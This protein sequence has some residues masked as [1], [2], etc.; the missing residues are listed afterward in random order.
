VIIK[1]SAGIFLVGLMTLQ[2][3][4]PEFV[5]AVSLSLDLQMLESAE[6]GSDRGVE[7]ASSQESLVFGMSKAACAHVGDH[8][9][10]L[11]G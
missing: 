10:F 2:V 7:V 5:L 9:V 8:S 4:L 11:G 6:A 1:F 3:A